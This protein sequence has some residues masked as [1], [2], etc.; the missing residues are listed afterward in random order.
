MLPTICATVSVVALD[1]QARGPT[2]RA[3]ASVAHPLLAVAA[4]TL[5]AAVLR[6]ARISHQGFWFDEANTAQLVHLS[7]GKMIGLVPQTQLEPPWYFAAA[8][9]WARI[10]G[11]GEAGL[12]SLSAVAGV[13]TVP[14]MY[15]T[16]AKLISRRA[17]LIV[18]AL[19]ATSPILIWYSQ[20]ARS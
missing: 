3:E 2:A 5:L 1:D 19:T 11:F 13:L 6:F 14:V 7:L 12:R 18:A 17:G 16:G 4:L 9:V 15:A 10:F 20:E 8:W